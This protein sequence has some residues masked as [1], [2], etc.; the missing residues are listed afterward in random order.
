M[1]LYYLI[2]NPLQSNYDN[3]NTVDYLYSFGIAG[4]SLCL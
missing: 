1:N 2:N 3:A 4:H